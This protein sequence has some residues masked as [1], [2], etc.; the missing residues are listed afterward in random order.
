MKTLTLSSAI[1]LGLAFVS[2]M[3]LVPMATSADTATARLGG[4]NALARVS[5]GQSQ[6]T[7]HASPSSNLLSHPTFASLRG[8][9]PEETPPAN[10]NSNTGGSTSSEQSDGENG[11]DATSAG[12]DGGNGG[13]P[14]TN[15]GQANGGATAGNGGDGGN[16]GEADPGGLVRAGSVVSNANGVNMLNI[17]VI[18]ITTR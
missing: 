15:S 7:V 16:G 5:I 1:S 2:A 11:A 17:N 18:R 12:G 3:L 10:D 8:G 13:N 14:S 9:Q 6:G 4:G